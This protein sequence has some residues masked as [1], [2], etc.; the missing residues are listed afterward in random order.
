LLGA[1]EISKKLVESE[2]SLSRLRMS[3][4]DMSGYVYL[5]GL[6]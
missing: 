5:I 3:A 6:S 1:G 2:C 4:L